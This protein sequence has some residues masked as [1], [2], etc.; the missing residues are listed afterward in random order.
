MAQM[1]LLK[2][3][4]GGAALVCLLA[5][6]SGCKT[7]NPTWGD[8]PKGAPPAIKSDVF[9][10]GDLVIVT[11]SGIDPAPLPHEERIK[12]DG[13]ITLPYIGS[14]VAT[15][16]T[17]G[18]L[19]KEIRDLYVP[20][21]FTASLNVTVKGQDRFFFVGGEV[22]LPNRYP[23]TEGLTVLKA[24]QTAGGFTDYAKRTKVTVTRLGGHKY[25]VDCDKALQ[26]PPLDLP[27]YPGDLINVP[28]KIW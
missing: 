12:D 11:F 3:L 19:P 20:A 2:K 25:K 10:L 28:R 16:K 13:T 27:V 1:N 7:S 24:I 9:N 23:Y 15:N 21:Y 6:F 17:P 14:V 4:A 26:S 22:R 18:Q 5:V 8:G